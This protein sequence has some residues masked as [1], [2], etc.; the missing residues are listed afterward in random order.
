MTKRFQLAVLVERGGVAGLGG[1]LRAF[2]HRIL[3]CQNASCNGPE[4]GARENQ[5]EPDCVAA[6]TI[7]TGVPVAVTEDSYVRE[8]S[9]K[10]NDDGAGDH[11]CYRTEEYVDEI[12]HA[13]CPIDLALNWQRQANIWKRIDGGN[14]GRPDFS[15]T[16]ITLRNEAIINSGV[17]ILTIHHYL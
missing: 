9:R 7:M 13:V 15:V 11:T 1:L 4:D 2:T 16:M 5:Q 17:T 10:I 8:R 6:S 14:T 3:D 12:Y